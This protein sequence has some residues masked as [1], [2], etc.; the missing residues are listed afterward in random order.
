MKLQKDLILGTLLGDGNL[1]TGRAQTEVRGAGPGIRPG[2]GDI[3]PFIK[4]LI[5]H[6]YY[7]SMTF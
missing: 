1:E 3:E 7:I 6:I 5:N 4:Q 2:I